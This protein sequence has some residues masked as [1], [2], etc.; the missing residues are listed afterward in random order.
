VDAI[1]GY[2]ANKIYFK[3]LQVAR[4]NFLFETPGYYLLDNGVGTPIVY[5]GNT[6]ESSST[7]A[8]IFAE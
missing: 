2:E 6:S 8:S 3:G 1:I 5:V 4:S 7:L